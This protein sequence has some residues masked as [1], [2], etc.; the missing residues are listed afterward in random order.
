[1]TSAT[2]ADARPSRTVG[3]FLSISIALLVAV[4]ILQTTLVGSLSRIVPGAIACMA[5]AAVGMRGWLPRALAPLILVGVYLAV[6]MFA[7]WQANDPEGPT[8]SRLHLLLGVSIIAM[9]VLCNDRERSI[10][11]RTVVLLA[12]VEGL[13]GIFEALASPGAIWGYSNKSVNGLPVLM[14]SQIFE[15]LIR[16]QGSLGHPLVLAFLM[17]TGIG[18]VIGFRPFNKW[19]RL[20]LIAVMFGG[21]LAA[22]SRSGLAVAALLLLFSA[23]HSATRVV[24]GIYFAVAGYVVLTLTGFWESEVW[25][26]FLNSDSL[27]HRQ[28]SFDAMSSLVNDQSAIQAWFGNGFWSTERLYRNGVLPSSN[29]FFAIDNQL[30]S[31]LAEVGI[32]GVIAIV[33]LGAASI[34]WGDRRYAWA[35][36]A[37]FAMFW[38]FEVLLWPSTYGILLALVGLAAKP[39]T[40]RS[41]HEQRQAP[42]PFAREPV[43]LD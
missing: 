13:Y 4:P 14:E 29:G 30:V 16:A 42:A 17:V 21:I 40:P 39:R 7:T 12:A 8:Q 28:S 34:V 35:I 20:A 33:G 27:G 2:D 3:I 38:T 5:L 24:Q 43:R 32:L 26:R 19:W 6:M 36:L 22:G 41:A 11:V 31:T 10:V 1:M 37:A 9:A 15:G 25:L 23:R 18:L